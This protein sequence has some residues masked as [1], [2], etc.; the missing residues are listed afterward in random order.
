MAIPIS[1]GTSGFSSAIISQLK[2]APET[3]IRNFQTLRMETFTPGRFN[4]EYQIVMAAADKKLSQA[5][6][7]QYFVGKGPRLIPSTGTETTDN[8]N[9]PIINE[10]ELNTMGE[11]PADFLAISTLE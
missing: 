9:P 10:V 7:S 2:A 8:K 4:N 5:S 3:G 1:E 11:I 6:A